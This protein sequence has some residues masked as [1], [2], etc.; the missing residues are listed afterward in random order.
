MI[1]AMMKQCEAV[2]T[3]IN[4]LITDIGINLW[5]ALKVTHRHLKYNKLSERVQKL[6]QNESINIVDYAPIYQTT[7]KALNVEWISQHWELEAPDHFALDN[8]E[9]YILDNDGV[10]LMARENQTPIGCCAL[11]K[12]DEFTYELAKMAVSPDARG[13]KIGWLLG[14]KI[15]ERAKLMGI[16]RL[17]LE[18]NSALEPA[19]NLYQK[20]GF[21]HI[22]N[23]SS[24]YN[25]CNVQ[26]ELFLAV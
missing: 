15:I 24:P 16:K 10:I 9:G 4:E 11:I 17:Y 22:K 3:V 1:P 2:D 5:E 6:N 18:S 8:P 21:T 7:F 25:R 23:T 26:M 19:I 14:K 13:K 20:L 12:I